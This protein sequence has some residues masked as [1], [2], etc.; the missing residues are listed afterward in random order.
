MSAR[1][2]CGA[3]I[4]QRLIAPTPVP[5]K[6]SSEQPPEHELGSK[7]KGMAIASVRDREINL[8]CANSLTL[9]SA[10]TAMILRVLRA[11]GDREQPVLGALQG[12]RPGFTPRKP[13][14]GQ[15][16]VCPHGYR[17]CGEQVKLKNF[18]RGAF[19]LTAVG[20]KISQIIVYIFE[21]LPR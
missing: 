16:G 5:V 11:V 20:I 1:R 7:R 12:H 18:G 4:R 15:P 17:A 19:G 21:M 3:P 2:S 9:L 14:G 8:Y 13:R 10:M 6:E